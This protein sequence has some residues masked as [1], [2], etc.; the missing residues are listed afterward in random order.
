MKTIIMF[1]AED[2]KRFMSAAECVEYEQQCVDLAAANDMLKNGGTFM[3]AITRAN[4][5]RPWWDTFFSLEDKVI[6]MK[7]TKDTRFVVNGCPCRPSSLR[8]G[9][10]DLV[11]VMLFPESDEGIVQYGN[12][13]SL[14]ELLCY[15]RDTEREHAKVV[16][17][18]IT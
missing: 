5:T 7:T 10:N 8:V 15:A 13:A 9:L 2:E 14:S 3:A 4:H 6:L 16:S 12:L 18:C 1:E 17:S 11:Q